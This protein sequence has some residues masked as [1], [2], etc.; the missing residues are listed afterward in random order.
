[1]G[2]A[3]SITEK[4]FEVMAQSLGQTIEEVKK[5]VAKNPNDPKWGTM[6]AKAAAAWGQPVAEA[7]KETVATIGRRMK[8]T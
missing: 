6:F 7:K 8:K 3:D 4:T 2:Y 5:E 1:M